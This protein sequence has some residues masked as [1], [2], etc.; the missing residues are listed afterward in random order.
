MAIEICKRRYLAL[1]PHNNITSNIQ[2]L[3]QDCRKIEFP[4]NKFDLILDKGTIDSIM[5]SEENESNAIKAVTEI[6]RVLQPGANFI[7]ISHATPE[8]REYLFKS[9]NNYFY[10][11]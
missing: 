9:N 4:D 11:F 6:N 5:C 2:F 10:G 8:N 1:N 7:I 3:C